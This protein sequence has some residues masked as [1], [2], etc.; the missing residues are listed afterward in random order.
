VRERNPAIRRDLVYM[1]DN[2]N[3]KGRD[4]SVEDYLF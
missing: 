2:T 1:L 4:N 3:R